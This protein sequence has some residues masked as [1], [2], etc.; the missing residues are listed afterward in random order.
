MSGTH[1]FIHCYTCGTHFL[2]LLLVSG[3]QKSTQGVIKLAL[4]SMLAGAYIGLGFALCMIGAGQV[5]V[6]QRRAVASTG[7]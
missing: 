7:V 3:T 1:S 6:Q 5:I 2:P 4:L